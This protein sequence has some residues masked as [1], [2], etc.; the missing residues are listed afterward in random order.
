VLT[1]SF[2]KARLIEWIIEKIV[3]FIP[4]RK[5]ITAVLD[6]SILKLTSEDVVAV[7]IPHFDDEIIGCFHFI[8]SLTTQLSID[9]YYITKPLSSEIANTRF[10][11]SSIATSNLLVRDR[12]WWHY[13]EGNLDENRNSLR[14]S[15]SELKN[16]YS[17]VL[18]PSPND[19]TPDHEVLAKVVLE[20]IPWEKLLWYRSTWLTFPLH[21][22][23]FVVVGDSGR[24]RS[25]LRCFKSQ[26]KLALQNVVSLSGLESKLCGVS[27]LSMEAFRFASTG[28]A[29]M[30]PLNV[31]S[32]KS[33]W[34]MV[35]WCRL[36]LFFRR[37]FR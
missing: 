5:K 27:A 12:F 33:L 20:V 4:A 3:Q 15:L 10:A 9:L 7:L 11:E 6:N 35:S 22:A 8:E 26:D 36:P 25:A 37:T 23:D 17:I 2:N 13:P 18:S 32:I 31:L 21:M 30:R 14:Q 28:M 16:R 29:P 19:I 1:F 24:K 34:N